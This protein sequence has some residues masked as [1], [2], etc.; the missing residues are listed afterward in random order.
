MKGSFL[1]PVF[2]LTTFTAFA[3]SPPDSLFEPGPGY[4]A[5][6]RPTGTVVRDYLN[7]VSAPVV[8]NFSR[9][10]GQARNISWFVRE[11]GYIAKFEQ[12]GISFQVL[13]DKRGLWV[14]TIKIY[15][16][17]QL[18]R[19]I[20]GIV[21]SVYYDFSITEVKEVEQYDIEGT[22]YILRLEDDSCWKTLRVCNG[23]MNEM[24]IIRKRSDR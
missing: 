6:T 19:G 21:K 23:E 20:R 13:Y 1:I 10:F 5:V 15:H 17:K 2:L 11:T 24:E 22:V 12:E 3:Q 9:K 7:S 4:A 14:Y 8:R 18:D 16:E